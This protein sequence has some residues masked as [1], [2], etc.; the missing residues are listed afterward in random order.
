LYGFAEAT[1]LRPIERDEGR[2]DQIAGGVNH[3]PRQVLAMHGAGVG[4]TEIA[5]KLEIGRA[6]V[7]RILRDQSS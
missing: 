4:A 1:G 6:P 3:L 7:Y 5:E 2:A